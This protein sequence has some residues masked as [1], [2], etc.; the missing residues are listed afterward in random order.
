MEKRM[1]KESTP[2][3]VRV[4]K[5]CGDTQPLTRGLVLAMAVVFLAGVARSQA[6]T[7]DFQF[8]Y[9]N[10]FSPNAEDYVVS[11]SNIVK[12]L[13]GNGTSFYCPAVTGTIATLRQ[14]FP[15]GSA[16]M[17]INMKARLTSWNYGPGVGYGSIWAS[18]DGQQWV[19]V[20]DNPLPTASFLSDVFF[21]LDLPESVLGEDHLWLEVRLFRSGGWYPGGG[22]HFSRGPVPEV[23]S[24]QAQ[25]WEGAMSG[26]L[27]SSTGGTFDSLQIN[28]SAGLPDRIVTVGVN[29]P[30]TISM[31]QPPLNLTPASFAIAGFIGLPGIDERTTLPF[32]LGTMAIPLTYLTPGYPGAFVLTN[33]VDPSLQQL[34]PSTPTPWSSSNA[35]L[36]FPFEFTFQGI[37]ESAP[38]TLAV[39]NAVV[40]RI[41]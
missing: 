29:Q 18:L 41:Q 35:G 12:Y 17:R 34:I 32:A 19:L 2:L 7:W 16:S 25:T 11:Q 26:N 40:L 14:Y 39:S 15:F 22:A 31:L 24:L 23:F 6:P 8:S 36:P 37:I 4:S 10:V 20:A 1:S 13:E 5:T 27:P 38:G 9:D 30:V 28:G 33:S 3:I 21:D